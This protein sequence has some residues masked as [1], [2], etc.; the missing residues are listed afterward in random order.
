MD[1]VMTYP[2]GTKVCKKSG[3]PLFSTHK[4]NT[5]KGISVDAGVICGEGG[6]RAWKP[7]DRL[8]FGGEKRAYTVQACDSRYLI[9]TKPFNL[10]HTVLYTIVDLNEGIRGAD[11][12]WKWGGH[13][14]YATREGCEEALKELRSGEIEISY[15]NRT[16]LYIVNVRSEMNKKFIVK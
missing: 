4:V 11:N 8:W 15:C 3:E 7:G 2:A 6:K 12:Y 16:E 14:N 1:D 13:V 5:V 9:C 10:Q